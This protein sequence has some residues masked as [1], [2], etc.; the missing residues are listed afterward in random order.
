MLRSRLVAFF[1][2][3]LVVAGV[4]VSTTTAAT[5]G[6]ADYQYTCQAPG[7]AA[8]AMPKGTPFRNCANGFI[9]ERLNGQL[10]RVIPTGSDGILKQQTVSKSQVDCLVA[11]AGT[12]V[13]VLTKGGAM[14]KLGTGISAT[15]LIN[16]IA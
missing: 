12:V 3:I 16:C 14:G 13:G 1:A 6:T 11:I 7:Q 4:T 10:K 2:T 8:W 5:A 9:Y 15:G